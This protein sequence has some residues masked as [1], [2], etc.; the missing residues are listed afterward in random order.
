MIKI[1]KGI[2]LTNNKNISKNEK[3][4]GVL[5]KKCVKFQGVVKDGLTDSFWK[6]P[7]PEQRPT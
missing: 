7:I 3:F 6:S 1:E 2:L 4:Q 5:R